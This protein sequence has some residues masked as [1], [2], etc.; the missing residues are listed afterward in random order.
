MIHYVRL[1]VR[2]LL[3]GRPACHNSNRAGSYNPYAPIG[4]LVNICATSNT[5]PKI[6]FGRWPSIDQADQPKTN[7]F[8]RLI[9]ER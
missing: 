7:R 1:M 4:A 6:Q 5:K 3:V 9:W 2:R 8:R